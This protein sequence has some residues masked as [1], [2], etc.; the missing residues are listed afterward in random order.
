MAMSEAAPCLMR[1]VSQPLFA[2]REFK[3]GDPLRALT[4]SVSFGRFMT[5]SL[6]WEKWSSFS[7]NRTREDVLKY[8]RPGAVAEKKAFF[9]AYFNKFASKKSA[10]PPNKENKPP[11]YSPTISHTRKNHINLVSST[12]SNTQEKQ[13]PTVATDDNSNSKGAESTI[14]SNQDVSSPSINLVSSK[15]TNVDDIISSTCLVEQG[16]PLTG[17][18]S[19]PFTNLLIPET[20]N[21][22][23]NAEEKVSSNRG[24]SAS[25]KGICSSPSNL[26]FLEDRNVDDIISSSGQMEQERKTSN[27]IISMENHWCKVKISKQTNQ[28]NKNKKRLIKDK[29]L[30]QSSVKSS[31]RKAPI[32]E[33]HPKNQIFKCDPRVPSVNVAE[34]NSQILTRP[35]NKWSK[36]LLGHSVNGNK[37]VVLKSH[38]SN[39]AD[40]LITSA[41]KTRSI[42]IPSAFS[43]KS[44]ERAAKRKQF[45]QKLEEKPKL[46]EEATSDD[47][48]LCWSMALDGN[49]SRSKTKGPI[50]KT[51]KIMQGQ[52]SQTL[53]QKL[54]MKPKNFIEIN[55]RNLS[56]SIACLPAKK[57]HYSLVSKK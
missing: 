50:S 25:N 29:I 47:K 33:S 26:V 44:D 52:P 41:K 21:V 36:T 4:T 13:S 11:N 32:S 48:K 34:K 40:T 37:T 12:I 35:E 20:R 17:N 42:T 6:D 18:V 14:T 16:K 39:L 23:G 5:E 2:S 19:S 30:G 54:G 51:Q 55:K 46:K 28:V 49:P 24:E 57:P 56:S 9:E 1:S 43:F 7:H 8:S 45:F 27:K 31:S 10:K 3:E 22:D 15:T 38:L 53:P